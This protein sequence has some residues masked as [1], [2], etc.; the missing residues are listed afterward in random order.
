MLVIV[1]VDNVRKENMFPLLRWG[2]KPK[3]LIDM[4]QGIYPSLFWIVITPFRE[5]IQ[6]FTKCQ[7]L[8]ELDNGK[9][10]PFLG[11]H[12]R[13]ESWARQPHLCS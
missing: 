10:M 11:M 9:A 3:N 7:L 1:K 4:C 5:Y 13:L 2:P 12:Y 6:V 8:R